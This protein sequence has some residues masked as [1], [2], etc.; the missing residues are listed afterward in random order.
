MLCGLSHFSFDRCKLCI[1]RTHGADLS[2]MGEDF[3]RALLLACLL[4]C[5]CSVAPVR[6]SLAPAGWTIS[7]VSLPLST[8]TRDLN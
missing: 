5:F 7:A 1:V 2:A 4:A 8:T 3:F 6:R